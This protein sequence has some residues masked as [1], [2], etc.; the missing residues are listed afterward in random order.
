MFPEQALYQL[1]DMMSGL[2]NILEACRLVEDPIRLAYTIKGMIILFPRDRCA[3]EIMEVYK[4][5][6][7]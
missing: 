3:T 2:L 4:G 6:A 5:V 7:R 1:V